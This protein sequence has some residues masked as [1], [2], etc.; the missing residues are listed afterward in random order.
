M[1]TLHNLARADA[2]AE[3]DGHFEAADNLAQDAEVLGA[4]RA[5][6]GT[7]EVDDVQAGGTLIDPALGDGDGIV[8]VEV[9]LL[10]LALGKADA[11]AAFEVDCRDAFH[12]LESFAF[13]R[14]L[15]QTEL[16]FTTILK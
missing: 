4:G 3:L 15:C 13:C 2:A 16:D 6:A 10:E 12:K 14:L 8:R 5:E 1:Y 7:V 11:L 9:L